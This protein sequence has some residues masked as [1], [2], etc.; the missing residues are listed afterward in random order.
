MPPDSNLEIELMRDVLDFERHDAGD[1]EAAHIAE[2]EHLVD[3]RQYLRRELASASVDLTI[4]SR[5]SGLPLCSLASSEMRRAAAL[6][7]RM[8]IVSLVGSLVPSLV[9]VAKP[10]FQAVRKRLCTSGS[11]FSNS[12][13][14][15]TERGASRSA[16]VT[17]P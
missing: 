15:I 3:P 1:I 8:K 16:V 11:A 13:S 9:S 12:S 2:G 6:V 14:N 7:V 10:S 5:S 4:R 17:W